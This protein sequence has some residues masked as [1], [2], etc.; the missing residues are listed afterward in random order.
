MWTGTLEIVE[1][2]SLLVDDC[3]P[4]QPFYLNSFQHKALTP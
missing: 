2:A 4:I 1:E 3:N